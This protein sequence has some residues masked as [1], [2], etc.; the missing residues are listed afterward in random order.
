MNRNLVLNLIHTSG[1]LSR[2]EIARRSG[3]SNATVSEISNELVMAGLVEEVGEGESTG[4]RRPS[5]LRL[6]AQ[7]GY[8]VGIK[9]MEQT[10]TCALADLNAKVIAHY[11]YPVGS[12]HSPEAIQAL[13]IKTITEAIHNAQISTDRVLGIGIGL[14][15]LIDARQRIICYSPYFDWHNV[16]LADRLIAHFNLPVY[17]ENDVNTLTVAEQWFGHGR[18]IENFVV[19]T[20]GRGIGSG[21]VMNGQFCREAAGEIGHLTMILNGPPCPCGKRG[22]LEAISAD[23]AVLRTVHE[24]LTDGHHSTLGQN[25]A[26]HERTLE[27]VVDAANNGD[28]LAC[29]ILENSGYFLGIGIAN[30]VNLLSPQLVIVSGEGMKAGKHRSDAMRRAISEHVFNGLGDHLKI[31]EEQIGDETWARGAAS[32]VLGEIFKSPVYGESKVIDRLLAASGAL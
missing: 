19:V 8:V 25:G 16:N 27:D 32:L 13:L 26:N 20:V 14:A 22:C 30:L 6:N 3:L 11:S 28:T 15:G 24:R 29:E 10:I 21:I 1:P 23:P 9:V 31:I 7:A 4:G 5:L 18:G 2:T 17:L 12:E